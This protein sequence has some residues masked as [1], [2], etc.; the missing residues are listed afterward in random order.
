M[1]NPNEPCMYP[2]LLF[3]NF[4]PSSCSLETSSS[5]KSEDL[6]D[7]VPNDYDNP[8]PSESPSDKEEPKG[9]IPLI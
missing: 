6:T 5:S 4:S 3:L 2:H 1:R 9:K 8:L 7:G